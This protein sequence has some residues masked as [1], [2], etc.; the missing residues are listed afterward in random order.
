MK[1]AGRVLEDLRAMYKE[2]ADIE[3]EYSKRLGKLAKQGFGKDETGSMRAAIDVVRMEIDQTSKTH[4]DLSTLIKKDLEGQLVELTSK[5]QNQRKNSLVQIEKLYKQ[6]QTQESYVAKSKDKYEQDCIKINGYTA[7]TSLVQGRD[8]DKVT[9]KLDKAQSTVSS[10]DK[11]YQNFVRALKDTTFRWNSEWK[12]YL[13][14]CQDLEEERLECLKSNL[15]NYANAISAVC[16]ADDESCE[17]VRVSLENCEAPKD[18][19]DFIQRA[20][21]GSAI[22]DPPEYINYSKGQPPP[23]RPTFKTARFQRSTT[24]QTPYLPTGPPPSMSVLAPSQ[25]SANNGA[26][27]PPVN[28]GPSSGPLDVQ[29]QSRTASLAQSSSQMA[30]RGA[31]VDADISSPSRQLPPGAVPLSG[32]APSNIQAVLSDPMQDDTTD[33][34]AIAAIAP[35]GSTPR[36]DK[37]MSTKNFLARTASM[38]KSNR[39]GPGGNQ[40]VSSETNSTVSTSHTTID[41]QDDPIAKALA[42][43]RMRPGGRSPGPQSPAQG[44]HS[45]GASQRNSQYGSIGPHRA[46]SPSSFGRAPSPS[47]AFMQEPTERSTSPLPVE[48]VVGQYH[49]HFPGERRAVS[50]Q[51]STASR[52]SRMSFQQAPPSD[53]AKSPGPL[54]ESGFAGVGARGRSPSPQPFHRPQQSSMSQAPLQQQRPTSQYANQPQKQQQAGRQA[55]NNAQA[56][57]APASS[58]LQSP[59][60]STTPLGIA[61][62]A[63]GSVTHDQMA[64]DFIKR[65]GSVGPGM[66]PSASQPAVQRVQQS[67]FGGPHGGMSSP[68]HGPGQGY[69]PPPVQQQQSYNQMGNQCA[70]QQQQKQHQQQGPPAQYGHQQQPYPQSQTPVPVLQQLPAHQDSMSSIRQDG[71]GGYSSPYN[72]TPAAAAPIAQAPTPLPGNNQAYGQQQQPLPPPQQQSMQQHGQYQAAP[73]QEAPAASY[74]HQYQQSH[75]AQQQPPPSSGTPGPGPV[76]QQAS[77]QQHAQPQQAPPHWGNQ[78]PTSMANSY[79]SQ[80][81]YHPQPQPQQHQPQPQPPIS[82]QAAAAIPSNIQSAPPTRQFNDVG[83]PILF[84]VTALYDYQATTDEEFSFTT[85]D[86]IAVWETNPDGWWMGE[87]LDDARRRPGANTFPSN[88]V[89]LLS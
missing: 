54:G 12:T 38:S 44:A 76:H 14:Q 77:Y 2:R 81:Q 62:D 46:V 37:R 17:R 45:N 84:Y 67:Q 15:W 16:V 87:L 42:N 8:L 40:V 6:K 60:R 73:V 88:F 66:R 80:G 30:H 22:A 36:N 72:R 3:A 4:A 89:S 61:L 32:M 65:S 47:A 33:S 53:R 9:T 58:K 24:R 48:E 86:I 21:T 49:Q 68:V 43:L 19:M 85:N 64:D 74:M 25:S 13:D 69:G 50:R 82:Q 35:Q 79:A 18:I 5:V 75:L 78:Q 26:A 29:V 71:F 56:R 51:N 28:K 7:Q 39:G 57:P 31:L 70:Q 20:G 63:S 59:V 34:A 11:D 23:P 10:N 27:P 52:K 41:H 1:G 83:K 55:L